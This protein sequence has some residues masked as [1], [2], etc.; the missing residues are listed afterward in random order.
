M[1]N[2]LEPIYQTGVK[3]YSSLTRQQALGKVAIGV[4]QNGVDI[5]V[6][7]GAVCFVSDTSGNSIFLNNLLFGD[8]AISG[9]SSSGGGSIVELKLENLQVTEDKTLADYF[10]GTTFIPEDIKIKDS[11]GDVVLTINSSGVKLGQSMLVTQSYVNE[12]IT[13]NNDTINQSLETLE[14]NLKQYADGLTVSVYRVKGSVNS[15][16]DLD[17]I[18]NPKVGDVYNVTTTGMNYV[19]TED[20][21]DQLGG[22]VDTSLFYNKQEVDSKITD[23]IIE[24]KNYT[25]TVVNKTNEAITLMQSSLTNAHEKLNINSQAIT[26]N[27]TQ[28][29]NN[30]NNITNIANQL[31]WQ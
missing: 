31:T 5:F 18:N 1:A 21:W 8:G 19:Y 6:E 2:K 25:E 14:G 4:D 27:T 10:D 12:L 7:P 17:K 28:I 30:T 3:F 15:R 20:G 26:S 24:A 29:T 13:N 16:S 9:G 11:S 23:S 22:S